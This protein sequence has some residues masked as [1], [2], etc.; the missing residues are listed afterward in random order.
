MSLISCWRNSNSIFYRKSTL[1]F[2]SFSV[3]N[4]HRTD[5]IYLAL[6]QSLFNW[7]RVSIFF[8]CLNF[9]LFT[10]V[11]ITLRAN[12][13]FFRI[14]L[15]LVFG[16]FFQLLALLELWVFFELP[17]RKDFKI[18]IAVIKKV[19]LEFNLIYF[20]FFIGFINLRHTY[21]H[22]IGK[23]QFHISS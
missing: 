9:Y 5:L 13:S 1:K 6:Q 21:F 7:K 23:N 3:K 17:I 20:W 16:V 10:F 15:F 12:L 11:L 2:F 14:A 18:C 22:E 8:S 19:Y 4:S